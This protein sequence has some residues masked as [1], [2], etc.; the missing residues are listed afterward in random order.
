MPWHVIINDP[1]DGS[2]VNDATDVMDN[3]NY[4]LQNLLP[5]N[6]AGTETDDTYNLGSAVFRWHN[7]Y[8][9]G[10]L[11]VDGNIYSP[12][13]NMQKYMCFVF[14]EIPSNSHSHA[15]GDA[16]VAGSAQETLSVTFPLFPGTPYLTYEGA[17]SI[18]F[19]G[20]LLTDVHQFIIYPVYSLDNPNISWTIPCTND[21]TVYWKLIDVNNGLVNSGNKGAGAGNLVITGGGGGV[22]PQGRYIL[23]IYCDNAGGGAAHHLQIGRWMRDE[24][25]TFDPTIVN[26]FV[27]S[28][29]RR[30][31]AAP[32]DIWSWTTL[33]DGIAL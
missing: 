5:L 24:N 12:W 19:T 18:S 21:D 4:R 9:G 3:F 14:K 25:C 6:N 7:I 32:A 31:Q 26:L 27:D 23:E 11:Y 1:C 20:I 10:D 28:N 2:Q 30:I 15:M 8:A 16:Y 17:L 22:I 29:N 33:G 13:T